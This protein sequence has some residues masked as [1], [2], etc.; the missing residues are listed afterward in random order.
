MIL[1][2]TSVCCC[3]VLSVDCWTDNETGACQVNTSWGAIRIGLYVRHVARWLRRFPLSQMHFV[4]G[5]QLV[6]DP[7][8]QLRH[9]ERFLRLRPFINQSHF[10]LDAT[11]GFPCIARPPTSSSGEVPAGPRCLGK[12]KGRAHPKL[13]DGVLRRLREFFRPHN[14]QFYRLVGVDFGWS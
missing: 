12:T 14:E 3:A 7:A 9:V 6:R 1:H 5:E 2:N 10:Q 4:H 13:A 8:V 11:K